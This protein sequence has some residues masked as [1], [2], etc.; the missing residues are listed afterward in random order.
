MTNKDI[1]DIVKEEFRVIPPAWKAA[2][3]LIEAG[4]S[5]QDVSDAC[6]AQ[7]VP[8]PDTCSTVNAMR[9][10]ELGLKPPRAFQ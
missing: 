9:N 8:D 1:A 2:H 4:V 5:Q 10:I 7:Y 6:R 3:R